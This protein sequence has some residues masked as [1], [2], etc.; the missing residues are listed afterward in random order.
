MSNS[1]SQV[2]IL[3]DYS[4]EIFPAQRHNNIVSL[5]NSVVY[6]IHHTPTPSPSGVSTIR[7]EKRAP[8]ALRPSGLDPELS[9]NQASNCET[10]KEGLNKI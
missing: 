8:E 6:S 9:R 5:H 10:A 1:R 7:V 2:L 4:A 3:N